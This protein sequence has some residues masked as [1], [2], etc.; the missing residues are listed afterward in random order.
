MLRIRKPQTSNTFCDEDVTKNSKVPRI[1]I[2]LS[3]LSLLIFSACT[4]TPGLLA[5]ESAIRVYLNTGFEYYRWEEGLRLM[6]W[7]DGIKASG[8]NTTTYGR[9]YELSCYAISED[10]IRFDWHLKTSDGTNSEFSID[11]KAYDLEDSNVFILASL[12]GE[13]HVKQL[14]RELSKLTAEAGSVTDFGLADP[15]ISELLQVPPQ[16]ADCI[17]STTVP[18]GTP[19]ESRMESAQQALIAFFSYLHAGEYGQAAELYRGEYDIMHHHNPEIDPD[20]LAALFRNA[21]TINGAQCLEIRHATLLDKPSTAEF[22]FAVQFVN[23]DG[24][25]FTLGPCCGDTDLNA[26]RQDEFLYTVR[27][28]CTGRYLVMEMPVYVP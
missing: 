7:I 13:P 22:R 23:E 4:V 28:E 27:L 5:P 16:I 24:S 18:V 19:Q 11:H 1:T 10:D 15:D 9:I 21:C 26:H 8:C 12:E 25:L 17:S 3:T 6:I 20:D 14:K 2:P